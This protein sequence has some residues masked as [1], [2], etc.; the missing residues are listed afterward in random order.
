MSRE[1]CTLID[2]GG[3]TTLRTRSE[4]RKQRLDQG[5]Q[6]V[7]DETFRQLIDYKSKIAQHNRL[8][9]SVF[10]PPPTSVINGFG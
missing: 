4:L 8:W 9:Q 10:T 3:A 6:L 7:R 1:H 2:R 5:P